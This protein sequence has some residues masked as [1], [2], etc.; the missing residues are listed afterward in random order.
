MVRELGEMPNCVVFNSRTE[1][2]GNSSIFTFSLLL[3]ALYRFLCLLFECDQ[4][5]VSNIFMAVFSDEHERLPPRHHHRRWE[6]VF[7]GPA[8][9]RVPTSAI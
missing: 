4:L 8:S 6:V 9:L 2:F 5:G 1:S 3:F 7:Q